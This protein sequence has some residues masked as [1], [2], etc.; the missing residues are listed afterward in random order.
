MQK[1]SLV[2]WTM[3]QMPFK[4]FLL[5]T[6]ILPTPEQSRRLMFRFWIGLLCIQT[7]E[8]QAKVR[9]PFKATRRTYALFQSLQIVA[10]S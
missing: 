6:T 8:D 1:R 3:Y 5:M 2:L 9:E 10:N 7:R 4:G